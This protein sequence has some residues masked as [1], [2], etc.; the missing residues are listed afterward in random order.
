MVQ[1]GSHIGSAASAADR[2]PLQEAE[3]LPVWLFLWLP[4][5]VALV[6][7]VAGHAD[8]KFY[9]AYIGSEVG[10]LEGS[11][12]IIPLISVVY[13]LRILA[14]PEARRDRLIFIWILLGM[15]G[16]IYLAGEEASWGQHYVG[17]VTPEGWQALNDQGETNLHNTSSWFDQ[18]PRSLLEI[19][20]IVGGIIIPLLALKRPQIRQ[21]RFA[22]FLPP[23]VCLP[24]AVIAEFAKT[25]ERL[26]SE[27]LWDIVI[28]QRASEIQELYFVLFILFYLVVFRKRLLA[29]RLAGPS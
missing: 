6:L 1:Q 10:V 18:K 23:L 7:I 8:L 27:G 17:W 13:C 26:Q 24:V 22:V 20:V 2:H 11:H 28:F 9:E 5:A 3:R 16:S 12:V 25:W 4:L 14:L 21:G 29:Q 15:L 19:G